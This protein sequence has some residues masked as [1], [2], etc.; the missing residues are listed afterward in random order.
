MGLFS[1]KNPQADAWAQRARE[2]AAQARESGRKA[3]ECRRRLASGTSEDRHADRYM[4]RQ[5]EADRRVH[6]A[7]ARD[8]W[9]MAR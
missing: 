5:H 1:K 6:E 3:D 2:A 9:T 4:L 7:N 8:W